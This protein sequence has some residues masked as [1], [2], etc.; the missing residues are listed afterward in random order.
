MSAAHESKQVAQGGRG[1]IRVKR[2]AAFA[3]IITGNRYVME[4]L[5]GGFWIR[6]GFRKGKKIAGCHKVLNTFS[7]VVRQR[8]RVESHRRPANSSKAS[9][10]RNSDAHKKSGRTRPTAHIRPLAKLT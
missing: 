7:L 5:I 10:A 8:V 1:R 9:A 2:D 3:P 4:K 6:Q